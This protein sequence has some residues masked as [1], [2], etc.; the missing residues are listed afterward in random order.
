MKLR[1][2]KTGDWENVGLTL[3][4]LKSRIHEGAKVAMVKAGLQMEKFAVKH[5]QAQ[6]MGWKNSPEWTERKKKLNL[7]EKVL[8]ATSTY[9]QSIT[10][11]Y[12][13][14]GSKFSVNAGV[15]KG[16]YEADGTEIANIAAVLEFGRKHKHLQHE[17]K[18][19]L[20]VPCEAF[21]FDWI[22]ESGVLEK[23]I[24]KQLR[25]KGVGSVTTRFKRTD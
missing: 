14:D 9:E 21:I 7:S 4:G 24:G 6:D 11:F 8:V 20:W 22:L 5:I 17:S 1:I 10:S 25:R 19:P 12:K 23:E 2:K 3:K 15:K 18:K 16:V 13:W